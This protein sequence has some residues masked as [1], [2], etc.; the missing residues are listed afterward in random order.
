MREII[1]IPSSFSYIKK[2]TVCTE[3]TEYFMIKMV[4]IIFREEYT[5]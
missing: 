5:D 3:K 1:V 4:I 2:N